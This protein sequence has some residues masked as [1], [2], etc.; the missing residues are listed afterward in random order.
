MPEYMRDVY[1]QVHRKIF[2]NYP[3]SEDLV[4]S[5]GHPLWLYPR[6]KI[7]TTKYTPIS[8]FPKNILFQFTNIA[9]TYF[10]FVIIL[11]AFLVF[12]VALPGLQ[13]VPLVVIVVVTAAKDAFEDYRRGKS[14]NE[15]NNSAI[16]LLSG[17]HNGNVLTEEVL[18]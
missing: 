7:R 2:V 4:N 11:G 3:P 15:L 16:H 13:A 6:N 18:G 5:H 9:N 10:L 8:F 1:L 12:G 17:F 14:D